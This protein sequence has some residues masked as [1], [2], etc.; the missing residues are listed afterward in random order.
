MGGLDGHSSI[1][2]LLSILFGAA[3]LTFIAAGTSIANI[4][5]IENTSDQPVYQYTDRNG[6]MAFTDDLSRIPAEYRSSAKII[7]LPS[8]IKLPESR[9]LPTPT[10]PSL[11]SRIRDWIAHL[12]VGYRLILF[13]ILPTLIVLWSGLCYLRKR[14]NSASV[15]FALRVGM[16]AIV[17][18]SVSLCYLTLVRVQAAT[19]TGGLLGGSD[20]ISSFK[21]RV[22]EL[23]TRTISFFTSFNNPDN[24][25]DK[26]EPT[27]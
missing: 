21:Q 25:D 8:L 19:V 20:M 18:L 14:T 4:T 24:S 11:T 13:G 3:V 1:Q 27:P 6:V 16:V 2:R 17:V 10:P 22:N 9:P 15:K 7:N 26:S 23:N 5:G 12:S